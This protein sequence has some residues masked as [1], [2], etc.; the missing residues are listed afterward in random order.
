[1]A[2]KTKKSAEEAESGE[3]AQAGQ[4]ADF[5]LKAAGGTEESGEAKPETS[6]QAEIPTAPK[7]QKPAAKKKAA[8]GE[9]AAGGAEISAPSPAPAAAAAENQGRVVKSKRKSSKKKLDTDQPELNAARQIV[10]G[11]DTKVH[12]S[13]AEGESSVVPAE[14]EARAQAAD[15]FEEAFEERVPAERRE[16][17]TGELAAELSTGGA[18][19]TEPLMNDEALEDEDEET[20]DDGMT[21]EPDKDED[22][23]LDEDLD[24]EDEDEDEPEFGDQTDEEF[25]AE[26]ADRPEP[27]LLRLQKILSQAGI[28]SRR[29]AEELITEGRVQ[30]NGQV[31]TELGSKADP[32]RDHIRVDGKLLHGAE[33]L[34]Y[35][36][37]NKPRGYVTT[38]SDP[39]GRPT[40]MEF[41]AKRSERLYPVGR[42]DYLSEGLL[43]M[44]NDGDLA[45]KLTKAATGVQKTYL[46]KVSGQP[47]EEELERLRQGVTIEKGKPGEG[48]VRTS[49]AD[50]RQVRQGDNPWYEVVLIE[51]RNRELRKMFEEI[52]HFVEKIR[53]VGYG[54]LVLDQEPG[55]M[56]ELEPEEVELLRKAA[57][58]KWRPKPRLKIEAERPRRRE[59]GERFAGPRGGQARTGKFARTR[60][61]GGE[62]GTRGRTEDRGER[63][64]GFVKRSPEGGGGF[65]PAG[66]REAGGSAGF[67]QKRAPGGFAG[68]SERPATGRGERPP[69]G[70]FD[71]PAAGAERPAW[72]RKDAAGGY[73]KRPAGGFS[74]ARPAG[75]GSRGTGGSKGWTGAEGR[76][77]ERGTRPAAKFGGKPDA[78]RG[79]AGS[80]RPQGSFGGRPVRPREEGGERPRFEEGRAERPRVGRPPAERTQFRPGPQRVTDRG[81]S[82]GGRFGEG[83]TRTGAGRGFG[84][85]ADSGAKPSA[86][87]GTGTGTRPSSRPV[88]GSAARP[89]ARSDRSSA[90]SG[91]PQGSFGGRPVRSGEGSGDFGARGAGR[92]AKREFGTGRP[93]SSGSDRPRTGP[94]SGGPNR[95][96]KPGGAGFK[97]PFKAGPGGGS[98]SSS[99]RTS[100]GRTGGGFSRG[101]AGRSSGK[102]SGGSGGGLRPGGKPGGGRGSSSGGGRGRGTGSGGKRS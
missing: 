59:D 55:Q 43:L 75:G 40:V 66:G 69:A 52:G 96:S 23:D 18:V 10:A 83:R 71:R 8:E 20:E 53:R 30:V 73:S 61:E 97:R 44:T 2:K 12:A 14:I 25:R 29:H 5:E 35:F 41:F 84:R 87:P 100:G 50:V 70:R 102:P 101:P 42:L 3:S 24:V 86:R 19:G 95:G 78:S 72:P 64:G 17:V 68:R 27:K 94:G 34:R 60:P 57:E 39:E 22:E 90:G 56:R 62:T 21:G 48:R 33:R 47:T 79:G 32:A 81:E 63:R 9:T 37:L 85:G 67:G 89:A 99:G 4:A 11:A 98:G 28:A 31:V 82:R 88:P 46:V 1:M 36:V 91:R 49:P 58:G 54:P 15:A 74:G 92:P 51:G 16:P 77:G 80:G 7:R 65:K 26:A 76:G 13:D 45:N 38:V 6:G 93:A